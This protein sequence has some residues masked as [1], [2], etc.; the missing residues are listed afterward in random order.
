MLKTIDILEN[1]LSQKTI[2]NPRNYRVDIDIQALLR[3]TYQDQAADEVS[4]QTTIGL[5]P[6]RFRSN[7]LIIKRNGLLGTKIDYADSAARGVANIHPDADA[8]HDAVKTLK[9]LW[10]GLIIDCAKTGSEPDWMPGKEP[11]PIKV[12]QKNGKPRMEFY[13][14]GTCR[15]PAYCLVRYEPEPDHLEFVRRIYVEWW[16]A[17]TVLVG[18]LNDLGDYNV[19]GPDAPRE[20]WL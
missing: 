19:S 5:Y 11:R 4:R 18:K 10:I 1:K 15:K 20:P 6:S 16:D 3:W 12:S 2:A 9:P 17:M 13:D 14:P 7:L 8:V